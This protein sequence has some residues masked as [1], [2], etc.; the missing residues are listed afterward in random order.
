MGETKYGKHIVTELKKDLILP[1]GPP[2][3]VREEYVPGQ[4]RPLEHVLWLDG[5]I[6][7]GCLYSECVWFFPSEPPSPEELERLR[8]AGVG[9][10]PHI[11]PF[12][13]LFTF[14]GTNFD[15][16]HDLGGE[17]EFWLED[18]QFVFSKSCLVYI[19]AG[20]KHCPL[21]F[22]KMDQRMFHFSMGSTQKYEATVIEG[23]GEYAGQDLS[24]YFVYQEKPN[25]ELPEYRHDI[26]RDVAHRV[27]YLDSEVVPGA[28]FYAEAVWFWPGKR[29]PPQPG[30]EPG[31]KPHSHPFDEMIGF[32]GTDENDIHDL[33]GEV[34]LWIEDERYL[35][36]KSFVAFIP[37]GVV[38]CPLN[39]TR[40]D[41]PIF[42]FTAGPGRVY[43]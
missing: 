12:D 20:M 33:C 17:V 26:P 36:D 23:S 25:L 15:D 1:W 2:G 40:I 18:Q 10:Q 6:A 42:H 35:I 32:F 22:R 9:P 41:R 43:E 24:K 8:K 27:V 37:A 31:V 7:P 28:N 19:P 14:F 11:H 39:I 5:E 16:P 21:Q 13:E 34:E 4:N 30:D 38:H 3:V 29:P